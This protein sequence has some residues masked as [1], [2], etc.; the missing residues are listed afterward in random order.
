MSESLVIHDILAAFDARTE[1]TGRAT[2]TR[3]EVVGHLGRSRVE[4]DPIFDE[5][6]EKGLLEEDTKYKD[7]WQL[8]AEGQ[9]ALD[10]Q[11]FA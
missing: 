1:K 5:A 6:V 8:S 3:V 2:S 9:L 4:V 7:F 11:L 10:E